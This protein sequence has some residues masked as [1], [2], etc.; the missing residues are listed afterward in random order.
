MP[1]TG[2]SLDTSTVKKVRKV[3]EEILSQN[4][5]LKAIIDAQVKGTSGNARIKARRKAIKK[6][7]TRNELFKNAANERF[8]RF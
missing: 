5:D 4:K 6:L 3:Y 8:A 1:K 2:H 7:A